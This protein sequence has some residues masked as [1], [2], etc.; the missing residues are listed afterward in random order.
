MVHQV[1]TTRC[2]YHRK[3]YQTISSSCQFINQ[4]QLINCVLFAKING[5]IETLLAASRYNTTVPDIAYPIRDCFITTCPGFGENG[6]ILL[7]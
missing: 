1:C 4:I 2:R 7:K 6:R 3:D 5:A